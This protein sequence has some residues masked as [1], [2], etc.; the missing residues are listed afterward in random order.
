MPV[1]LSTRRWTCLSLYTPVNISLHAGEPLSLYMPANLSL[2]TR[3][4]T[5]PSI[6]LYK[7]N[8]LF[9]K[10]D[11]FTTEAAN[12]VVIQQNFLLN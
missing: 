1:N 5:S 2:F 9:D 3:R 7:P 12:K 6:Y 11:I 10:A 8:T 4:Q